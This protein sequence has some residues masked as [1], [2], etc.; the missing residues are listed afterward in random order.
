[1]PLMTKEAKK[2]FPEWTKEHQDAFEAIKGIIVSRECLTAI[3]HEKP[4]DNKIFVTCDASDWR[5]GT[6]LSFGPTWELARPVTFDSAQLK[7][8][9][10]NYPIHKK[11]LLAIV[12]ALQKWRSDL[13]GGPIFVY[14]DHRTLENFDSQRKLSWR[15]LRWQEYLSQYDMMIVY[16]RGEENT[17][18]NALSITSSFGLI[19]QGGFG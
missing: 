10:K 4:G 2:Q 18:A 13:L 1:M 6:T 14:T 9:E 8:A 3:E 16:I 17:V 19:A 15:Q 12:R 7:L 11:E 5:T